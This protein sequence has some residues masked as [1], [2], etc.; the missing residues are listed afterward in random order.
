M[1]T[2]IHAYDNHTTIFPS[3]LIVSFEVFY[4]GSLLWH[5]DRTFPA[6]STL[7]PQLCCFLTVSR[8]LRLILTLQSSLSFNIVLFPVLGFNR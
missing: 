6:T 7:N 5:S 1:S 8:I 3:S 4:V 2:G